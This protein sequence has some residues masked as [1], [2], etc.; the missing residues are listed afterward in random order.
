MPISTDR[1]TIVRTSPAE[2]G[3][4]HVWTTER[5]IMDRL[6]RAGYKPDPSRSGKHGHFYTIPSKMFLIRTRVPRRSS[7]VSKPPRNP[8]QSGK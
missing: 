3:I 8:R 2:P 6:Q 4:A 5:K 7:Y 1:E